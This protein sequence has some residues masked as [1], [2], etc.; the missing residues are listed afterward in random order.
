[1][2]LPSRPDVE[3]AAHRIAGSVRRTPQLD[4]VVAGVPVSFKLEQLQVTGSFKARGALNAV[5]SL[6]GPPAAVVAASG[7]NHGL[8]VAWAAGQLGIFAT[9]VV[10]EPT[11]AEKTRRLGLFGATVVRHGAVY[12]E[13]EAHARLLADQLHAPFVHPY[14][15]PAVIAGQGTVG[16]EVLADADCD[17]VVL[18]VGGGGLIAGVATALDGSGV[19]VVGAEPTGIPTLHAALAAGA[20]VEVA[21]DSVTASALGARRTGTLNLA[22]AQE[23]VR[24]VVLVP[25]DRILAARDLLWEELR[26]AVEPAA[27]TGLAAVLDGAVEAE[28]PCVVLCGANSAWTPAEQAAG[29]GQPS[30]GA[31]LPTAGRR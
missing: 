16:L 7:G 26:L 9:V 12:A 8:G 3:A 1:M 25:D 5:L 28:R 17:A 23:R 27:A 29:R 13:A 21:A 19:A 31:G 4:A 2:E 10:P 24:E 18:A 11:P 15:D 20:P 6:V 14:E 30:A 22:I